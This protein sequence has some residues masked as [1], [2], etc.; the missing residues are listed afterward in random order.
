MNKSKFILGIII[1]LI[2]VIAGFGGFQILHNLH[3][4]ATVPETETASLKPVSSQISADGTITAQN[5]ATLNFQTGGKLIYLPFKEGDHVNQGQT[6]A[7]LDTYALQKD[8]QLAA[9]AYE[10][11]KNNND[12]TQ[13]N[14]QAGVI[15]G[16]QRNA[17]DTTNKNS[18]Q[19]TTEAQVV[20]DAVKRFVDN[21]IV[22][23]NSAQL[24]IDLANYALQLST[25][26]SPLTGIV[27]HEDV[28]VP[29]QNITP[30][31]SFVVADPSSLVFRANVLDTD[32][33][34]V[35]EGSTA[36]IFIN[37]SSMP[38][39]GTVTKIYPSKITL[40]SGQQGYQVDISSDSIKHMKMDQAGTVLI[41]SSAKQNTML[42]PAWT[43]LGNKYIWVDIN[44]EPILKT[45]TVGKTYGDEIEV[46]NGL[47]PDDK[48]IIN[49]QTITA[50]SY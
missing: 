1:G 25:L 44:N 9:N 15:E 10:I 4:Q 36:Q 29:Y 5:Q 2:L 14:N 41:A 42:V 23:Q 16:Q 18:Y 34:Y 21:S 13:E 50:R 11:S 45:I 48:V 17:L 12:Q 37:G 8:L 22:N 32:I 33:D 49:P 31:T 35:S 40:P 30:L 26:T 28:T 7:Q 3:A 47:I 20:T 27:T 6:I 43:V 24:N 38:I 19:N 39:S 46:L